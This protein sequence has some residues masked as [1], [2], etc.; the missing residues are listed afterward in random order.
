MPILAVAA[1]AL[2]CAISQ[3]FSMSQVLSYPIPT[4]LVASGDARTIAYAVNRQGRH[5][6][7][8]ARAPQYAPKE[9]VDY[10]NDDGRGVG[11]VQLDE[12]G[13][14]L[15]YVYGSGH[16]PSSSTVQPEAQVWTVDLATGARTM[17][18]AGNSPAVSPDGS[19][20][21]FLREGAVWT[22]P[23]DGSKPAAKLFYDRGKD[24]DLQW[25]PKGDAL[26]FVSSRSDHSFI[27][28]YRAGA[29]SLQFLAPSVHNDMEP[30]WS[31]DGTRIAFARTPGDGGAP[32]SPLAKPIIPWS[33]LVA[34]VSD[35]SAREIWRS[36][37]TPRASFPTMGGDVSLTWA[38]N[39]RLLFVSEMDNWPHLYAIGAN[40][41]TPRRLTGGNFAVTTFAVSR[42]AASVLYSAN[43]GTTP[44]DADRW[45]LYR[46]GIA[47]GKLQMLTSGA[48]AQWWPTPLTGGEIAYVSATAQQPP[49]VTLADANGS[50]AHPID[51][52]L[53]PAD[54]PASRLITPK[55]VTY[56]APDGMLIH[57]QLF[58]AP[59]AARKP[60]VIFVHGGPMRQM[61]LTWNP[62]GYYSNAYAVNQYLASRG[63][64]VLSVNYRTGVDFGHDFH[65]ARRSAWTGASEYQDVLAGARWLQKQSDV[66][67]HRIG[68]WGGSWGGYLTAL[69]LG[70]NSGVFKAGVDFSGVHNLMHDAV[71]YF[72]GEGQLRT[73]LKPWLRLAWRSSPISSVPKWRSP[74]L[75]IQGDDDPDVSFHQ[76][77][78]LVPRLQ[79][80]HV[81]YELMVLPNEAHS[82]LRYGSWLRADEATA[83]FF[84]RKL[85]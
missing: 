14:H 20:V 78:D 75:L 39:E 70:R 21:A 79:Q 37:H 61:L 85:R 68:I 64:A 44:G 24:W 67:P 76:M 77:V 43:T 60:A 58:A 18:S 55:D 73:D 56:H 10:P 71:G 59:G 31:P 45:H 11:S 63:F 34:R 62:S 25:S 57:A 36:P 48:S 19:R 35:G 66:D 54:F 32:P 72:Q 7:W 23:V 4:T 42:D 69:A 38:G 53:I 2:A 47:T 8:I 17:L 12:N 28:V 6:I 26:A 46:A 30:R 52:S 9:I 83:D 49:L 5:S 3:C 74:V 15:I 41:G 29:D 27:G 82:F 1:G 22:A 81:P 16:N 50:H 51:A 65:Y 80:Y 40:G 33:I 13:S 84:G